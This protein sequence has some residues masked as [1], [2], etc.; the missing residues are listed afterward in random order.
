VPSEKVEVN[1][2]LQ[3]FQP[4]TA[5]FVIINNMPYIWLILSVRQSPNVDQ[6]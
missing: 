5:R 3:D 1:I 6:P 2:W 4:A